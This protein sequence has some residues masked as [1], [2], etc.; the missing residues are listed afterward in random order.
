MFMGLKAARLRGVLEAFVDNYPR[1]TVANPRGLSRQEG[2][3]GEGEL[4]WPDVIANQ[5][6]GQFLPPSLYA[7]SD[8]N[9]AV[10]LAYQLSST[11]GLSTTEVEESIT[12][13]QQLLRR[14]AVASEVTVEQLKHVQELAVGIPEIGPLLF[15]P[16]NLA[17]TFVNAANLTAAMAQNQRLF[18]LLDLS[19]E[20]K[21]QLKRWIDNRGKAGARSAK[22]ISKGNIK[23]VWLGGSLH[24]QIPATAQ[25]MDYTSRYM[26][27]GKV[28]VPVYGAGRALSKRAWVAADGARGLL[29]YSTNNVAGMVLA[30]GPQ[31]YLDYKSSTTMKEFYKK[32]AYSQPTNVTAAVAGIAT[33]SLVIVGATFFGLAAPLYLVISISWAASIGVQAFIGS[34]KIDKTI[35]NYIVDWW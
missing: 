16:G 9:A 12:L 18:D 21:G 3:L 10:F 29:K 14:L 27:G 33:G 15:S 28:N 7:T 1:C 2:L 30:V 23:L 26:A 4:P 8:Y 13:L 25:A 31:A 6:F 5:R 20:Q 34:R 24:F 22:K 32:S 17:G 19:P 35:G 11:E